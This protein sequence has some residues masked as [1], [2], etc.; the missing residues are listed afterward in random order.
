MESGV[1][2]GVESDWRVG[3]VRWWR[4]TGELGGG[5]VESEWRVGW[6]RGV[7]SDWRVGWGAW[8]GE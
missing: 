2:R 7:E 5:E 4:V 8:G 6:G 3:W 1:G